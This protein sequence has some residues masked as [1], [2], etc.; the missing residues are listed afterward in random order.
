MQILKSHSRPAAVAALALAGALL[1]GCG[2]M[3]R[4]GLGGKQSPTVE[5]SG[6]Q[7]VPPVSTRASGKSTITVAADRTVSGMV[8]VSD[9]TPTMAHIHQ[10]ERGK[11]GPPIIT[12]V[13]ESDKVFRVPANARLTDEQHAAYKAGNLYINVH[14]AAYPNGEIRVQM[15]P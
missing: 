8:I 15:K 2:A 1:A 14:S 12:L 11:N 9:M 5:L 7:E 6:A 10:G 3:E 4:I 13:K